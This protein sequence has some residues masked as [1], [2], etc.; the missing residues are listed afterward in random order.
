MRKRK[1]RDHEQQP[2]APQPA[3]PPPSS[4]RLE[5][6]LDDLVSLLRSQ[7]VERQTQS[8]QQSPVALSTEHNTPSTLT[9]LVDSSVVWT[10][11]RY[12]DVEIDV[13]DNVVHCLRP[14]D[15]PNDL[16][17]GTGSSSSVVH[18]DVSAHQI[19]EQIANEQLETFR[20]AF[21]SMF[22]F[23]HIPESMT[24]S[25]LR[26]QRPFLWLV[27]MALT[28]K[29]VSQQF[30]M[31]ETI[32]KIISSRVVSQHLADLDLLLGIICFGSWSVSLLILETANYLW[33]TICRSHYF[34]QDKPFMTTLAQLSVSLAVE[35]DLH[36]D[37][38]TNIRR[39]KKHGWLAPK[40]PKPRVRTLEER[41]TFL[42]V[43]HLTSA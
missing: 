27:I 2:P 16:P 39:R 31:E 23:V 41:R 29:M 25:Q 28:T 24:A 26:Q 6:K 15:E 36:K 40:P 18:D 10:P 4:S 38:P 17:F 7:A 1:I 13:K 19:P 5:E 12:P 11:V 43:Y 32:W 14:G 22:P 33:L 35:L 3:P 21:I 37:I 42:A 30:A 9:T 8:Q 34:K 20:R